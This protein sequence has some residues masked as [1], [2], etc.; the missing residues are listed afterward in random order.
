MDPE[1]TTP[2]KSKKFLKIALGVLGTLA[3]LLGAAYFLT[4]QKNAKQAVPQAEV[5]VPTKREYT[6]QEK[7]QIATN[8]RALISEVAIP[9]AEKERRAKVLRKSIS[10]S[11]TTPT[12]EEKERLA[13]ILISNMQ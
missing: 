8:L 10:I 7:E 11:S 5:V 4:A 1:E 12:P 6:Q 9:T 13:Q 3:V 2:S